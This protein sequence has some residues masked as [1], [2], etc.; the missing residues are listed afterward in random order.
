MPAFL[1][2]L[3][4]SLV[5]LAS[6]AS[7]DVD[8]A[9]IRALLAS[10][11][12]QAATD[13]VRVSRSGEYFFN[14]LRHIERTLH[15]KGALDDAQVAC[16]DK[17]KLEDLE[18]GLAITLISHHDPQVIEHALAF[19]SS[20]VGS[21]FMRMVYEKNWRNRP[22]DFPLPPD[23][24]KESMTFG[25]M[26]EVMVFKE[27]PLTGPFVDPRMIT[28]WDEAHRATALLWRLTQYQCGIPED[29]LK[30]NP[31]KASP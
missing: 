21:L 10:P 13:L 31:F 6:P 28:Q 14:M 27:A 23:R 15:G 2:A 20:P 25:Q 24:P 9:G 5:L 18:Q 30:E 19:Y 3:T 22:D 26:R 8:E 11:L 17:L 16:L 7:G 29:V 12:G 4:T 1:P